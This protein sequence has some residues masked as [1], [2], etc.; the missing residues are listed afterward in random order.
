MARSLEVLLFGPPLFPFVVPSLLAPLSVYYV[1]LLTSTRVH[2]QRVPCSVRRSSTPAKGEEGAAAR[3]AAE[4][5]PLPP[6]QR[7]GCVG[8]GVSPPLSPPSLY[9]FM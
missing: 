2:T 5:I 6:D 3:P 9:P 1:S 7:S 4:I 8:K